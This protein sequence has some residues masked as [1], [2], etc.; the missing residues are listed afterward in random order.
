[1]IRCSFF[2]DRYGYY[3][4]SCIIKSITNI[5]E[6]EIRRNSERNQKEMRA[7]GD[8]VK[9][10]QQRAKNATD[11]AEDYARKAKNARVRAQDYMRKAEYAQKRA[12]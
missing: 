7:C 11:K 10:Y 3:S 5:I 8:S 9:T 6:H 12:K 1:M 4:R 2:V